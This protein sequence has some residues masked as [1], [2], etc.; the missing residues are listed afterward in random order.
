[1]SLKYLKQIILA[2]LCVATLTACVPWKENPNE[3]SQANP[4]GK[5]PAGS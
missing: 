3:P 5:G 4:S 2:A 1:M